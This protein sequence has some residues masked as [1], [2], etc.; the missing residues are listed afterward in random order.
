MSLP[1]T[2]IENYTLSITHEF[3]PNE[4][5]K[6]SHSFGWSGSFDRLAEVLV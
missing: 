6:E 1:A 4:A 3:L 2:E 5:S